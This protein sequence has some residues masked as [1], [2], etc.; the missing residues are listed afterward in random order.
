M[1][2]LFTGNLLAQ[3]PLPENS[4]IYPQ[5]V[6]YYFQSAYFHIAILQLVLTIISIY[7]LQF[8]YKKILLS[9]L[10]ASLIAVLTYFVSPILHGGGLR[11]PLPT[12]SEILTEQ[13]FCEKPFVLNILI[14]LVSPL[15]AT[16]MKIRVMVNK[17]TSKN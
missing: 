15:V 14:A 12:Y 16:A 11:C 17:L 8:R 2:T 4:E 1:H 3:T 6:D 7:I 5:V 9:I 13:F 10:F